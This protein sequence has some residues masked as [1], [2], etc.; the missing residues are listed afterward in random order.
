MLIW[1]AVDALKKRMTREKLVILLTCVL[2]GFLLLHH[3]TFGGKQLGARYAVDM[4]P[5]TV[6]YLLVSAEKK[7][8]HWTEWLFLGGTMV[9]MIVAL[10]LFGL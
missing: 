8:L 6:L 7:K 1:S 3:R 9:F 10:Y 4:I 5:Y 2:H